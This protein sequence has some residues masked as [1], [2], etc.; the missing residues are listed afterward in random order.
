MKRERFKRAQNFEDSNIIRIT[1]QVLPIWKV[2]LSWIGML[3]VFFL[4]LQITHWLLGPVIFTVGMVGI[5]G[6]Q[7]GFSSLRK[8]FGPMKSGTKRWIGGYL[9][10]SF[11]F[12]LVIVFVFM[13]S[14]SSHTSMDAINKL[15]FLDFLLVM[16]G[17]TFS[18]I[19][20]EVLVAILAFPVF[21]YLNQL[22]SLKKSAFFL[23]SVFSS[24]IFGLAHLQVY[25]WDWFQCLVVTGLG[26]IFFN[27]A[28]RKSDSLWAGFWVHT[29]NNWISFGISYMDISKLH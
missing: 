7:Y 18:L 22:S 2:L 24:L 23:S 26:R 8:F 27:Y 11:V 3:A 16:G 20:E 28:W 4:Y 15:P 5:L 17:M 9:V 6:Y 29:I 14:V 13:P 12:S 10:L 21:G 1:S 25:D 19:G